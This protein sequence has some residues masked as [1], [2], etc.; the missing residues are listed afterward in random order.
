MLMEIVTKW[1][2]SA[3]FLSM[4]LFFSKNK[5]VL[6]TQFKIIREKDKLPSHFLTNAVSTAI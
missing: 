1:Q 6:H 5:Y 2:R 3:F 4:L